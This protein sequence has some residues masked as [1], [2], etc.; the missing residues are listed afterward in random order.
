MDNLPEILTGIAATL[1]ALAVLLRA[2]R[3]QPERNEDEPRA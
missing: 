2:A 3:E 1:T